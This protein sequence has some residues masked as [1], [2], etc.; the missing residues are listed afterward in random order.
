VLAAIGLLGLPPLAGPTLATT[1]RRMTLPQV[2][3][4]SE[5]ILEGKVDS[6]RSYWEGSQIL[7]E[8]R[9]TVSRAFKGIGAPGAS[10]AFVQLGGRVASPVPLEMVVPGA[11]VHR[12]GDEG[13]YFLQAGAPGQRVIVG[14]TRGHVP[15]RRDAQ[16]TFVIFDG[17]RRTPAE[18]ADAI[19]GALAG[20]AARGP[21]GDR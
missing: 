12:V 19:R 16:G 5:T 2:V 13:F 15:I 18:F 6:V 7:T 21:R 20:Q 8:V 14:L 11:P 1:I 9:L 17:A 10:V 3:E 4:A